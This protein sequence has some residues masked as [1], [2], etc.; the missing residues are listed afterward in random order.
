MITDVD[1]R[2]IVER[3]PQLYTSDRI[4]WKSASGL[5]SN[6]E[7]FRLFQPPS[8]KMAWYSLLMGPFRIPRNCFMLWLA[9]LGRLTTL[10]RPW[11]SGTAQACVLCPYGVDESHDHLLFECTFSQQCLRILKTENL[12][13][14][15][16]CYMNFSE[17]YFC[18]FFILNGT[19][20]YPKEISDWVFQWWLSYGP[21]IS[22]ILEIFPEYY[23]E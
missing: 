20:R 2:E 15:M 4:I 1:H 9:I 6:V 5:F 13:N 7:A 10:D 8:P 12:E 3:L 21:P 18:N 22:I 23:A 14:S 19:Y 17:L 11:W 16:G